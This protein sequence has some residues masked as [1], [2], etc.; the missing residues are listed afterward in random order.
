MKTSLRT[1]MVVGMFSAF[2][3]EGSSDLVMNHVFSRALESADIKSTPGPLPGMTGWVAKG[4]PVELQ[5]EA[6]FDLSVRGR[7]G[8]WV[9]IEEPF[10]TGLA[11]VEMNSPLL[12]SPGLFEYGISSRSNFFGFSWQWKNI[13]GV[14]APKT[15]R[16][17]TPGVPGPFWVHVAVEWDREKG[18]FNSYL[19]GTP[20]R[21]PGTV[22]P[23]W[24]TPPGKELVLYIGNH[25]VTDVA[26]ADALWDEAAL[27]SEVTPVYWRS[28]DGLLGAY[29]P[30]PISFENSKGELIKG[31]SLAESGQ[32]KDWVM[33]GPGR[34]T[35]EEGWMRMVSERPDSNDGSFVFW[36]PLDLPADFVAEFE[37]RLLGLEGLN[38]LFFC[39]SG[40]EGRNL[41]DPSQ[42]R[43]DGV[44]E[45]YHSGDIDCYHVSYFANTPNEPGRAT[46][47]LRRNKGFFLVTNG[48]AALP[49]DS[50]Q[51]HR[52]ELMKHGGHIQLAVDGRRIIDF[53]D[54]GNTYGPVLGGGKIGFRQ[55]NWSRAEYRNLRIHSLRKE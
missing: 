2:S 34:V 1:L 43:R 15:L 5:G 6:G 32:V 14:N 41:F 55:M 50:K 9:R 51:V 28:F 13:E 54:D 29:E 22:V 38:I 30:P 23:C 48:P 16:V 24:T 39:A 46:V 25:A 53:V 47:N 44:F 26:V 33:E 40:K 42:A 4:A 10:R 49:P 19:N 3:A 45:R 7:L 37:F 21:I 18:V 17:L 35:F 20:A 52:I 11:A 36:P 12:S 27:K 8:F 31:W